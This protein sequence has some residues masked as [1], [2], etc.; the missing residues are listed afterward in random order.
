MVI[1]PDGHKRCTKCGVEYPATTEF[2]HRDKKRRGGLH[3]HCK[4]CRCEQRLQYN[5][6]YRDEDRERS[7]LYHAAH[8]EKRRENQRRYRASKLNVEGIHTVA[9][10]WELWKRQAGTCLYCG[11]ELDLNVGPYEDRKAHL[12]HF[13][14]FNHD[15]RNSKENLAWSCRICNLSKNDLLPWNWPGWNGSYP[16]F[17]DGRLL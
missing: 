13:I 15:G 14:P 5:A 1:V 8:P 9:D 2:Y 11:C 10:E 4:T 6:F 17:W 12:D 16:V 7:K 3:P